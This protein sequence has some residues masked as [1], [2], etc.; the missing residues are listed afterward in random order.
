MRWRPK[1]LRCLPVE[2]FRFKPRLAWWYWWPS[3][4]CPFL[5][6]SIF[7]KATRNPQITNIRNLL[8][9]NQFFRSLLETEISC[10]LLPSFPNSKTLHSS[11]TIPIH[12]FNTNSWIL[13]NFYHSHSFKNAKVNIDYIRI[14]CNFIKKKYWSKL[15]ASKNPKISLRA[16]GSLSEKYFVTNSQHKM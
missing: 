6:S 8:E 16:K 13:L 1:W 15:E 4:L 14:Y 7:T 5:I 3:S 10:F 2:E 11:K 9:K 12:I